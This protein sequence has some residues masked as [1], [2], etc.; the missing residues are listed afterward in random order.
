VTAQYPS[1]ERLPCHRC[2]WR[3]EKTVLSSKYGG[4]V[5]HL[6]HT[7]RRLGPPCANND[8]TSLYQHT[9]LNTEASIV[10]RPC[11]FH[12]TLESLFFF[13][14]SDQNS[15]CF[16]TSSFDWDVCIVLGGR[17]VHYRLFRLLIL[18]RVDSR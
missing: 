6:I 8:S 3:A 7:T 4:A 15:N 16:S 17:R 9:E 1:K 14:S 11:F 2:W 12:S 10:T 18:D 13:V 5:L